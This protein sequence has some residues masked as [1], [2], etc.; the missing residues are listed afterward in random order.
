MDYAAE[1]ERFDTFHYDI[2]TTNR[3]TAPLALLAINDITSPHQCPKV[4]QLSPR[5]SRI[6]IIT[7]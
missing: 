7:H 5:V 4:D 6:I 2:C 1:T 3:Q